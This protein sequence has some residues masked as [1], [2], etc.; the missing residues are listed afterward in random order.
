MWLDIG[1]FDSLVDGNFPSLTLTKS[2]IIVC[3]AKQDAGTCIIGFETFVSLVGKESDVV[4]R[5]RTKTL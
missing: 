1:N 2:G 5:C 3:L 4:I